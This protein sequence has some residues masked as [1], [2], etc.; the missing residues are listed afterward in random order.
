M[1]SQ[2]TQFPTRK[3][4]FWLC[5]FAA[6]CGFLY[7]IHGILLPFVVGMMAAYFLDPAADWLEEKGCSRTIAT[8][9]ITVIFFGVVT[10]LLVTLIPIMYEQFSNLMA[11]MPGHVRDMRE[12]LRPYIQELFSHFTTRPITETNETLNEAS[13]S[14]FTVIKKFV[15]QLFSSSFA[16]LNLATLLL[17]TPVV[18]FYLLRDW[19]KMIGKVNELLP[20]QHSTMIRRQAR[21]I[22]YTI[23]AYLRGQVN[24]CLL[25]CVYYVSALWGFV[26]LN[27]AILV[28]ILAGLISFIP[29]VGAV[30]SLL[31]ALGVAYFQFG[32]AAGIIKVFIVFGFGLFLEN[33]VLIPKLVG[34]KVGLHPAWVIFGMLTGGALLGFVGVLMAV[35]LTAIIGVLARFAV[36]QYQESAMYEAE[37]PPQKTKKKVSETKAKK[38]T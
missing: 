28:G 1:A 37:D 27:Y 14:V 30:V 19:D 11:A 5:L 6:F 15:T 13:S 7:L 36:E 23:A 35:P 8:S 26:G 38:A 33:N 34:D 31:A 16:L 21:L 22:D 17:L 12:M 18:T 2:A 4:W 24:V 32:D 29:F 20:R 25:L 10:A 9:I 3:M